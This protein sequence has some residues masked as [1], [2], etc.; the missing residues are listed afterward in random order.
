[1]TGRADP[2]NADRCLVR[3]G[4]EIGNQPFQ[5]IRR[6]V[7]SADDQKRFAADLNDRF[8]IFQ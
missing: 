3:I 2:G 6:Q 8:Q 5:I 7:L 1:M 4:L